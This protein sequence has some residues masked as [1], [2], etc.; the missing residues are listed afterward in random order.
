V[1]KAL[2]E[3]RSDANEDLRQELTKLNHDVAEALGVAPDA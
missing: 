2:A 3:D 1:A